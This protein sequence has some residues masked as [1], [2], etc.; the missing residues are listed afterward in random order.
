[1]SENQQS[2]TPGNGHANGSGPDNGSAAE[3]TISQLFEDYQ[4]GFNDFD[5]DRICDCFTLPAT[6]WQHDKGHVF[7][8]DEELLE[9]IEALLAA[10]DKE[11]V[12]HS[13]FQVLSSHISGGSAMV[14]LD[15]Q[16][17]GSGGETIIEFTCHYHLI[18]DG[19]DWAIAMI[20]NE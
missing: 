4:A 8:D 19:P 11:G 7:N 13:E 1:M 3:E 6:I 20:I 17:E 15:W 18:Q 16:Q 2:D 5:A 14:T 9:N 10:L 12:S